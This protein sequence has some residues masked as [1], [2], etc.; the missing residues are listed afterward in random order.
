MQANQSVRSRQG[1]GVTLHLLLMTVA[2]GSPLG[3][4]EGVVPL[5]QCA[6]LSTT[7]GV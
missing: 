2:G 5:D 1:L 7:H 3:V 6:D 4:G